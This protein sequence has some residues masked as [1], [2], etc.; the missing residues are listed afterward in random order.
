MNA[1]KLAWMVFAAIGLAGCGTTGPVA[2]GGGGTGAGGLVTTKDDCP[3][4]PFIKG[5]VNGCS[6][7]VCPTPVI[8]QWDGKACQVMV[9]AQTIKMS[10]GNKDAQLH[11]WLP[12]SSNWEFREES[13]LFALPIL[14]SDQNA[15]GLRAQFSNANVV[16]NGKAAHLKNANTNS[17][18]YQY[19]VRVFKKG[20]GPRDYIDSTDPAIQNDN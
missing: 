10:K 18:K 15:P 16:G 12:D 19:Q 7:G 14:F 2:M 17:T 20:G 9:G 11:W 8:V 5:E 13:S 1:T 3:G 4:P 6:T